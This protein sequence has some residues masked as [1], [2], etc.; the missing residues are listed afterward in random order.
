MRIVDTQQP[1]PKVRPGRGRRAAVLLALLAT[2]GCQSQDSRSA[3]ETPQLEG[4]RG[5]IVISLDTLRA[6]HLGAYG[7]DKAT[8]PFLD[9]LAAQGALFERQISQYPSTLTSHMSIFTG[10]YPREHQV[11]PPDGVLAETIE[12][13]PEAFQRS[14]FR[15]A[16]YTEAGYVRGHYGFRRGFDEFRARDRTGKS[17]GARG[18]LGRGLR[19]LRSLEPQEPFFLFLHTYA[20]HAP[21][22]PPEE[23][24]QMFWPGQAPEGAF[25]PSGKELSRR[26]ALG[27]QLSPELLDYLRALY[28]GEIRFLDRCLKEFFAEVE[29]LGL[30]DQITVVITSDH[31]EEFQDHGRLNHEQL[32]DEILHIPLIFRHPDLPAGQR[33]A[34]LVESVDLAPTLLALAEITPRARMSGQ[35]LLPLLA[36]GPGW[37]KKDAYSEASANHRSL[38]RRQ[39]GE[40][41][42]LQVFGQA[43]KGWIS[44]RAR[45]RVPAGPLSFEARSFGEERPLSIHHRDQELL[46]APLSAEW[47]KISLEVSSQQPWATLELSVPSCQ[48]IASPD[49]PAGIICRGFDLRSISQARLELYELTED[50]AEAVDL[51]VAQESEA[52]DLV[53]RLGEHRHRPRASALRQELDEESK[54]NLKALGY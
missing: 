24:R 45:L 43:E 52:R 25:Y 23:E 44:R 30:G 11:F 12:T 21:Y 18:T 35:S 22:D 2:L 4:T 3:P 33:I 49:A 14:G 6:D 27:E 7:Y 29:A 36:N 9:G 40:L 10:L 20:V 15:T 50:P 42:H 5:Y 19:F 48:E 53:R 26:N 31:G 17:Q 37:Q 28:D 34:E 13:L 51:A 54:S 39:E 8:S 1:R 38:Y 32:Y 47:S 16:G 46:V 41:L